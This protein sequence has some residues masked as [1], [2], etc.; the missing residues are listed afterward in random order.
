MM[1]VGLTMR[2]CSVC[3]PSLTTSLNSLTMQSEYT[4]TCTSVTAIVLV[5]LSQLVVAFESTHV[6]VHNF[7]VALIAP[8][9][10]I[11]RWSSSSTIMWI[12][13]KLVAIP[14]C[15]SALCHP[16]WDGCHF[17]YVHSMMSLPSN[18]FYSAVL[19]SSLIMAALHSRCGHY[20]FAL[21]FLLFFP[22]LISAVA[23]WMSTILPH[24]V[25][26]WCEFRMQV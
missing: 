2:P 13:C 15:I 16:L 19:V 23:D 7:Y 26:P 12:F 4:H 18:W 20:I 8:A 6:I 24:M 9:G 22:R 25:W 21:W 1:D 10:G 11:V 17:L 14:Q 5:N 3:T